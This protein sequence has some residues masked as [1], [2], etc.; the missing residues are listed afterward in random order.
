MNSIK[1]YVEELIQLCGI[2]GHSVPVVRHLLLVLIAIFL[3]W[4]AGALCRRIL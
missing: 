4:A 2:T 3:A 1:N